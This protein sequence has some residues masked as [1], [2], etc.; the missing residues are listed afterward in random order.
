MISVLGGMLGGMAQIF[1]MAGIP[2]SP[3]VTAIITGLTLAVLLGVGRY[4]MVE[5]VCIGL[6]IL[7]TLSTIFALVA[8]QFTDFEVSSAQVIEGLQFKL[9]DNFAV[10]FAALGLIGL[11]AGE[12]IYYP[13]WCLEKGYAKRVGPRDAGWLERVNGWMR[14]MRIDAFAS[15]IVYTSATVVFYLLGAAVLHAQKVEDNGC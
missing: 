1:T 10:A 6:V 15:L 9:P 8:L 3:Q 14:V 11:G 7:F 12:L 5:R 4:T 2:L 13:Y